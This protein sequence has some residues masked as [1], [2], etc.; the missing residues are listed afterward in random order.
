[1]LDYHAHSVALDEFT[2]TLSA[3][4][5]PDPDVEGAR[6]RAVQAVADE[7]GGALLGAFVH[8]L[9]AHAASDGAELD[10]LRRAADLWSRGRA[11]CDRLGTIRADLET[12]M[13]DPGDPG[14]ADRLNTATVR[15][16]ELAN[17]AIGIDHEVDELRAAALEFPHLPPHPR[18]SGRD[19]DVWGWGDLQLAR[20]TD[21]V[22]RSLMRRAEDTGTLGFA[23]GVAGAYGASATGSA[24]LAHAVGGPRRLHRHRDRLA[25]N[26]VGAALAAQH[27]AARTP[28]A[29]AASL[30]A[31]LPAAIEQAL[32]DALGEAFDLTRTQ[33]VPDLRLGHRRLVEHLQLL[34]RFDLPAAPAPPAQVWLA[35]LYSDPGNPPPSLRPQ[36]VDVVGQ[37]GGGVAVEMGPGQPGSKT[38]GD[39]D[40][41]KASKG[42]GIAVLLIILIDLL[43]AFVQCIGQW[44]NGNRCTFWKNMLLSKLWE[45]DPPSPQDPA[46][47]GVSQQQLTVVGAQPEAAEFVSVLYDAHA[48]AWEA[49]S[50]ARAFLVLTG[51]V[52]PTQ[53]AGLP[54]HEQFLSLQELGSFVHR[55]E[56][57]PV[58]AFHRRPTTPIEHRDEMSSPYPHG[59]GPAVFLDPTSRLHAATVSF[60]LWIQVVRGEQ[61]SQNLDL[62]ADRG[63]GHA[64][65]TAPSVHDDP[66]DVTVLGYDEQ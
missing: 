30:G 8:H 3:A 49:M 40:S 66:V 28:T 15:A 61:D 52:Y 27:P 54:L 48:Q 60:G 9:V 63:W 53:L 13:A 12:A 38:A 25:R 17:E 10:L 11:A 51:L 20:R 1:M 58:A 64:C 29:M 56:P 59:A 6:E 57:D 7:P 21:A 34:D 33:P 65:W 32:Q 4:T 2:A 5:F 24:Y 19:T 43:Q 31:E 37:D 22:V 36:D 18:Q 50:R 35:R 62:D 23:V 42:C 26:T 14:A 46:N 16:Q 55:E 47:P 45:E 44:A 39:S 41:A